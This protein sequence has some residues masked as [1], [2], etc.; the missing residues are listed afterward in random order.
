MYVCIRGSL[1]TG[2]AG[3]TVIESMLH[4]TVKAQGFSILIC[5]SF[6]CVMFS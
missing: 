6:L 4:N 3:K 2:P 5:L 1:N